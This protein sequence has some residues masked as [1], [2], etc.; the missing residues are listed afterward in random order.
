MLDGTILKTPY[1]VLRL[2]QFSRCTCISIVQAM[3]VL[4]V[5]SAYFR[6]SE[7]RNILQI[8]NIICVNGIH[9]LNGVIIFITGHV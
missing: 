2:P 6:Q 9:I 7:A 8:C 5:Y 1:V 4:H 3:H